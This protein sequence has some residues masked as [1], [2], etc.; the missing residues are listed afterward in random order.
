M[1][2][3]S[4][5]MGRQH[6][7]KGTNSYI[8]WLSGA[9]LVALI[10]TGGFWGYKK[11]VM[12]REQAAQKVFA[13][14][15]HEYTMVLAG[16]GTWENVEELSRVGYEDHKNSNLAPYFLAL[17]ADALLAQNKQEEAAKIFDTLLTSLPKKSPLYSLYA[18]K[19]ALI[20]IDR[21][22]SAGAATMGLEQLKALADDTKNLQRDV[23]LYYLGLYYWSENS[24]QEAQKA[25]QEL[26]D[27]Q[28]DQKVP[29]PWAARAREKMPTAA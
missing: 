9:V 14:C 29:S 13:D 12:H 6:R 18:T 15:M 1:S 2:V 20:N 3:L 16:N 24:I 28:Q 27:M 17:Q 4:K 23:A 10:A 26:I 21:G 22:E 19:R 5:F 11:Y 25:W 8:I 7:G